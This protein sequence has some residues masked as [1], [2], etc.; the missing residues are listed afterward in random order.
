MAL[1]CESGK[2]VWSDNTP[3]ANVFSS[4]PTGS[5][6]VATIGGVEQAIFPGG[7]GWLYSFDVAAIAR[8]ETRLL[9]KFDVNDKR[10]VH[11][12]GGKSER[13]RVV[14][15]PTV[16][17][18]QVLVV[19]GDSPESGEGPGRLWCIDA[20]RRGD[21]SPEQVFNRADPEREIPHKRRLAC[22]EA[23][24]DFTRPNPNEGVIWSHQ[25]FDLDGDGKLKFDESIHRA[26]GPVVVAGGLAIVADGSGIVHAFDVRNGAL[27]WTHDLLAAV[28]AA[29]LVVGDQIY[30]ADEDGEVT[31]FHLSRAKVV[32]AKNSLRTSVFAAPV[33]DGELLFVPTKQQLHLIGP[34]R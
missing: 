2:P 5:P 1:D 11:L 34:R 24:G 17:G 29:P 33:A 4:C 22:D 3:G 31:V 18:D 6:A 8:G 25:S 15:R 23:A 28:W 20:T 30:V 21:L 7:D 12:L 16:H 32:M 9:W 10:A 26:I 13:L 19:V 14:G 27:L